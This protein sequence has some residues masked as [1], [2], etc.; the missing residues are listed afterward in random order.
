ME[1]HVLNN[2][3]GAPDVCVAKLTSA[4]TFLWVNNSTGGTYA[5]VPAAITV[6]PTGNSY[7]CGSFF[8]DTLNFSNNQLYNEGLSD[9]FIAKLEHVLSSTTVSVNE[10]RLSIFPN[11]FTKSFAV[12]NHTN[13]TQYRLATLTGQLI[14]EGGNIEVNDF[15]YL[16]AG[17][18]IL[19]AKTNESTHFVK[20]DKR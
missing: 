20:V 8:S 14:F 2:P 18:Y 7:I 11:P 6:D 16:P 1:G 13:N 3:A 9:L 10:G 12:K 19:E 5:E 4:G 17:I 15:S